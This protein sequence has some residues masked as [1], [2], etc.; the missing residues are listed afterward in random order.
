MKTQFAADKLSLQQVQVDE[1]ERITSRHQENCAE[2]ERRLTALSA[3]L[4]EAHEKEVAYIRKELEEKC[5]SVEHHFASRESQ[6]KA[7]IQE[8]KELLLQPG[9]T[10][11]VSHFV[12]QII[13]Y[14]IIMHILERGG[15]VDLATSSA[16]FNLSGFLKRGSAHERR[17]VLLLETD[18]SNYFRL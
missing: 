7:Q 2:Y 6:L 13:K 9:E 16:A 12:N 8:L 5:N 1:L 14:A 10:T 4:K 17:Y 3:H 11:K 15:D 18:R